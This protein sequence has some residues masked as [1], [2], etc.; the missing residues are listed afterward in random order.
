MCQH[1]AEHGAEKNS[2]FLS[3]VMAVESQAHQLQAV[4]LTAIT[5]LLQRH[6]F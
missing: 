6:E 4:A 3:I 1:I 2:S 5:A